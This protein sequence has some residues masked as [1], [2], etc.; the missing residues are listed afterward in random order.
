[1][2]THDTLY[3]L[4]KKTSCKPNWRLYLIHED[5]LELVISVLGPNSRD[6]GRT[7]EV[8]HHFL[9]PLADYN[10]KSWRRWVFEKCRDVENHEL[11]EW[12]LVDGY[13][14]YAPLH[15]PGDNP[16]F[17]RELSTPEEVATKQDGSKEEHT[18][19]PSPEDSGPDMRCPACLAEKK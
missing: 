18:C 1:M 11:S 17:I 13:R 4:I 8:S 14:P 3:A 12:F 2:P 10:E 9:V 19:N 7:I 6:L 5:A 16:Y 15:G